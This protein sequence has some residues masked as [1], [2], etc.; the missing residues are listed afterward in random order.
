VQKIIDDLEKIKQHFKIVG[1]VLEML[2]SMG[3]D[4]P[5]TLEAVGS[6]D[7]AISA[8]KNASPVAYGPASYLQYLGIPQHVRGYRYLI[9]AVGRVLDDPDALFGITKK[10]YH[11][12]ANAHGSSP[13]RVERGIRHAIE[14]AWD[15]DGMAVGLF[16]RP[17]RPTNT[18]FIA[19]VAE[20][21]RIGQEAKCVGVS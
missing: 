6:I 3:D 10:M 17:G 19:A 9:D 16:S 13:S 12:I 1:E 11:D 21:L 7:N 5:K 2:V 8:L 14:L 18:E 20:R 4:I 15:Y